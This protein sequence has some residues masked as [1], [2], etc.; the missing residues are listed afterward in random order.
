MSLLI[1]EGFEGTGYEESWTETTDTGCTLDEDSTTPAGIP[2]GS[3]CLEC[4][5]IDYVDNQ[6]HIRQDFGAGGKAT[7][8][9]GCYFYLNSLHATAR[10][11][12]VLYVMSTTYAD[13]LQ[14]ILLEDSGTLKLR[15]DYYDDGSLKSTATISASIQTWTL[16]EYKYDT[17]GGA[18]EWKVDGVTQHSGSL[19]GTLRTPRYFH[20]GI[21]NCN[22]TTAIT[23]YVDSVRADDETWTHTVVVVSNRSWKRRRNTIAAVT[24]K[25]C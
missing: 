1:N 22:N 18:W 25:V 2:E 13:N 9:G 6:A 7:L 12:N 3:Q 16:V 14:I 20:A 11:L 8:Y 17:S 19:T 24:R 21:H 10:Y 15:F 23:N 5:I 4:Y